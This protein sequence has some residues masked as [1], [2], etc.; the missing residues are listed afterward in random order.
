MADVDV[1]YNEDQ[2]PLEAL[3]RAIDRPGDYCAQGRLFVPMPLVEVEG[4]GPLSFPI[5]AQQAHALPLA[6]GHRQVVGQRAGPQAGAHMH[7]EGERRRP[8]IAP[9]LGRHQRIGFQIGAMPAM[10]LRNAHREQP[11][12]VQVLVVRHREDRLAVPLFGAFREPVLA[13]PP[14]RGAKRRLF[15][16]EAVIVRIEHRR[17]ALPGLRRHLTTSACRGNFRPPG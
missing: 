10:L 5:T 9:D 1:A 15:V 17:I 13:K 8:A 14:G 11:G 6:A 2:A 16:A 12:L 4:A 7:V 3:L